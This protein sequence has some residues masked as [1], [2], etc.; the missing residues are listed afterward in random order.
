M[1][2]CLEIT[3]RDI[4]SYFCAVSW[5]RWCSYVQYMIT[6]VA[7]GSFA[8]TQ[9]CRMH[10]VNTVHSEIYCESIATKAKCTIL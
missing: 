5:G 9:G 10:R 2:K 8:D 6:E 7:M 4:F 3:C 1:R